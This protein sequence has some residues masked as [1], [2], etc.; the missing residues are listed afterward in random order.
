MLDRTLLCACLH[1][2]GTSR[3]TY[4]VEPG[5]AEAITRRCHKCKKG[6]RFRISYMCRYL[7]RS[8]GTAIY[9]RSVARERA[10]KARQAAGE[11]SE[12]A[13]G[14]EERTDSVSVMYHGND[15]RVREGPTKNHKVVGTAKVEVMYRQIVRRGRWRRIQLGDGS[16]GWAGCREV[17][18]IG[19]APRT[20]VE[21]PQDQTA[22]GKGGMSDAEDKSI[23]RSLLDDMEI[24][25]AYAYTGIISGTDFYVVGDWNQTGNTFAVSTRGADSPLGVS[26]GIKWFPWSEINVGFAPTLRLE[27]S[28]A[29]MGIDWVNQYGIPVDSSSV[30]VTFGASCGYKLRIDRDILRMGRDLLG[31]GKNLHFIPELGIGFAYFKSTPEGDAL[32]DDS[33]MLMTPALLF[34]AAFEVD[35]SQIV[36]LYLAVQFHV[37]F[38]WKAIRSFDNRDSVSG[39]TDG[40]AHLWKFIA[41]LTF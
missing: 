24:E 4:R 13:A 29:E 38:A 19:Q 21:G 2:Y 17:K 22:A 8:S 12:E 30:Q 37:T 1:P 25:I 9:S 6:E 5:S 26:L 23:R 34:R 20:Y 41:G 28:S 14:A 39:D 3:I 32:N 27:I 15:C 35:V 31:P 16:T 40:G 18:E 36:A 7:V 33:F 10:K 11:N